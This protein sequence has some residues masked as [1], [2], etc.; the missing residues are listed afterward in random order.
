MNPKNIAIAHFHFKV[1]FVITT[2]SSA[3]A[4]WSPVEDKM[5]NHKCAIDKL[6]L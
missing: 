6:M 1:F 4:S 2:R 5:H 3:A